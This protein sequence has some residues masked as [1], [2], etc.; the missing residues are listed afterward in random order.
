M[1]ELVD[2][3]ACS[4]AALRARGCPPRASATAGGAPAAADAAATPAASTPASSPPTGRHTARGTLHT[5]GRW[6]TTLLPMNYMHD[7]GWVS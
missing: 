2:E 1:Q 7:R 4:A 3:L 5:L 6:L